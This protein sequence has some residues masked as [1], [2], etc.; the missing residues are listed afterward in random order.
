MSDLYQAA[1]E[2]GVKTTYYLHVKPRH[3]AEQS[4]T[5]VNKAKSIG[6]TSASGN[7][8]RG[9]GGFAR[10]ASAANPAAPTSPAVPTT[11]AATTEEPQET[12]PAQTNVMI[13]TAS[14]G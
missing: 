5:K 1:W 6:T 4:T 13:R 7:G 2:Y 11:T 14:T 10:G 3:G 12:A 8:R 9:F